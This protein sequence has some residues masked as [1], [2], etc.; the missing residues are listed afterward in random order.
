MSEIGKKQCSIDDTAAS[1]FQRFMGWYLPKALLWFYRRAR[2]ALNGANWPG[3]AINVQIFLF[4]LFSFPIFY[5]AFHKLRKTL[6]R[7]NCVRVELYLN[8][9]LQ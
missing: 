4:F 6:R 7:I 9:S 2:C 5:Y 1:A 3:T 8:R